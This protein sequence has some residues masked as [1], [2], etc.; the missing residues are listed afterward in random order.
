MS[1]R[2]LLVLML[3]ALLGVAVPGWWPQARDL[4][5]VPANSWR[6][7]VTADFDQRARMTL[8]DDYAVYRMLVEDVPEDG[9]LGVHVV[10]DAARMAEIYEEFKRGVRGP[11]LPDMLR[12]HLLKALLFPRRVMGAHVL[13]EQTPGPR[14]VLAPSG[15]ELAQAARFEKASE[16]PG[17][18]LWRAKA[19][20]R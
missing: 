10:R 15:V 14:F 13:P 7:M 20:G 9:W 12:M 11:E 6:V 2:V 4:L 3:L 17:F 8:P 1:R 16:V 19:P 18:T 5:A